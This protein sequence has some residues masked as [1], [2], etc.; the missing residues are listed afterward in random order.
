MYQ[1]GIVGCGGISRVH[2]A[3]LDQLPETH[4][5]AC[6]DIRPERAQAMAEKYGCHAYSSL[7]DMLAHEKLDAVHLCTPHYLH[8]PMA[9]LLAEKGIA[10]FS[11]KPPVI[12]REQWATLEEAAK[13]VPLGICF[14]NRYNPNVREAKRIIEAGEFGAVVGARA[15]VT[16]KR[17]APYYTE[18]GWRGTWATEGGG[19]L[20]N[21]S[22]HTLDLL[23][24]LMGAPSLVEAHMS[25]HH[26]KGVIEV[27][28]A[29]EAYLLL[30]GKPALFYAS[31]AYTQDAPIMVEIQLEQATL[32]IEETWLDIRKDGQTERRDFAVPQAL[33]KGYW[34]TGHL[35]CIRDFYHSLATGEHFQNDLESV[36]NTAEAMLQ[37]Y[38]QRKKDLIK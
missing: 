13:K 20:I 22:I 35:T 26:L 25:N 9:A 2:S 28:D 5:A 10:V 7:E 14:Q 21:Q 4:L 36:R 18:S 38:E 34:G 16:W 6:A 11:E 24:Q 12:S 30:G 23:V 27:E 29:L 8:T 3:V 17:E 19:A 33:G 32:R 37:I 1:V 15:F 31:T